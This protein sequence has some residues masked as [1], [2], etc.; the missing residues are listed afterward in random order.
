MT[1]YTVF[2]DI[3]WYDES[4]E[5]TSEDECGRIDLTQDLGTFATEAEAVAFRDWIIEKAREYPRI[6]P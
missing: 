6:K 5:Y 2:I 3:E 4:K 1:E